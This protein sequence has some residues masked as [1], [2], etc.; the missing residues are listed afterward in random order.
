MN[1]IKFYYNGLKINGGKLQASLFSK[2]NYFEDSGIPK[3]SITIYKK[4]TK[5]DDKTRFSKEVLEFFAVKNDSDKMMDY[6]ESDSILVRPD[7]ALYPEVLKAFESRQS[8]IAKK[9]A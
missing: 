7:H 2:G 1:T 8:R 3:E 9:S 4:H 5:S 6:F